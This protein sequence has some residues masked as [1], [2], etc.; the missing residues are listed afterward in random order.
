MSWGHHA[1]GSFLLAVTR[2]ARAQHWRFGDMKPLPGLGEAEL[3]AVVRYLR[4]AQTAN[5]IV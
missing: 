3:E 1:D 5:G 4:A 2:G